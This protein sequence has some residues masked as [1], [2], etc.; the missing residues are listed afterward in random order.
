MDNQFTQSIDLQ[1][2]F[3]SHPVQRKITR[4]QLHHTW[5]P[6][7]SSF[8]GQNHQRL[9]D[10]MRRYHMEERG[11]SDIGQH[12]TIFPDGA[13]LLGRS[14]EQNPAGIVGANSGAICIE[15]LGNFDKGKDEM[16]SA[17]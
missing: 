11:W 12:F 2:W 14:L 9:Q 6:D 7:Y 4:I 17:Q 15:C 1:D 3:S 16:S 10:S 8:D 13:V 5:K